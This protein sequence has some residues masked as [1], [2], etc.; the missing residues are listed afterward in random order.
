MICIRK[1]WVRVWMRCDG[2]WVVKVVLRVFSFMRIIS[3]AE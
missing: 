3:W 2:C 1:G